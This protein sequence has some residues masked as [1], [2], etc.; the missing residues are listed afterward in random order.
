VLPFGEPGQRRTFNTIA[1]SGDGKHLVLA[2]AFPWKPHV[3]IPPGDPDVRV[4][5]VVGATV[6]QFVRLDAGI[7]PAV[8]LPQGAAKRGIG[9]RTVERVRLGRAVRVASS[10][11]LDVIQ[12]AQPSDLL[13]RSTSAG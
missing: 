11:S 3:S 7:A 1:L 10:T 2:G 5:D 6:P 8:I 9:V 13:G 12:R 4:F